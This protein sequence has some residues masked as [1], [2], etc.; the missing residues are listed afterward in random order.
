MACSVYLSERVADRAATICFRLGG[1]LAIAVIS[2]LLLT[3]GSA[4]SDG[5]P[6]PVPPSRW[7]LESR[8]GVSWLITPCG[9]RFFSVGVNSLSDTSS[10]PLRWS[11][12]R[13]SWLAASRASNPGAR[14]AARQVRA[15]GFN[16]VGASSS[17]NLPLPSLPDLDLGWRASFHW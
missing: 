1:S 7:K 9:E 8:D 17:P 6:A 5:G 15:W 3:A 13:H 14:C 12:E 10:P 2:F 4:A 11:R 16:T